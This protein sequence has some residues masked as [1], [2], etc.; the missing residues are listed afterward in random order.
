MPRD[1]KPRSQVGYTLFYL[2]CTEVD[3]ADI[4]KFCSIHNSY[5]FIL[6][7]SWY[8]SIYISS[9]NIFSNNNYRQFVFLLLRELQ[10]QFQTILYAKMVI[11]NF[12]IKDFV[13]EM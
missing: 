9:R 3:E 4:C 6:Q 1:G 8:S 12:L 5:S 11:D 10:A 7:R 13:S 2:D